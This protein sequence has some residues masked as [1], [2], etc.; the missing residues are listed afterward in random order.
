MDTAYATP[1][2]TQEQ[3]DGEADVPHDLPSSVMAK[4]KS[5]AIT[6]EPEH[7]QFLVV[8]LAVIVRHEKECTPSFPC[9]RSKYL[10]AADFVVRLLRRRTL[11]RV[12]RSVLL[13]AD[14]V[15][16]CVLTVMCCADHGCC[17][18]SLVHCRIMSCRFSERD[19]RSTSC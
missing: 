16:S 6:L 3:A 19:T 1:Y 11:P 13:W 14:H 15:C 4:H 18:V 8:M 9:D 17:V 12:L 2:G 5:I 7:V 10:V